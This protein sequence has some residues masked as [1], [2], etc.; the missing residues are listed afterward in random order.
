LVPLAEVEEKIVR[1]AETVF[2][3]HMV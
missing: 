1:H 2:G 3:I